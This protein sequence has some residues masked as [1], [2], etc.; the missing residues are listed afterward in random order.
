MIFSPLLLYSPIQALAAS[1]KLTQTL[2]I[3][4]L[5]GI[6]THGP[7]V[8]ASEDRLLDNTNTKYE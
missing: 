6:Q 8:R 3:H 7:G 1:M 5:S 2:N 4:A